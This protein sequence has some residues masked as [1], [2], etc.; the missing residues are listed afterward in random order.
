[1]SPHTLSSASAPR[2]SSGVQI[3][4]QAILVNPVVSQRADP[5]VYRH[6]DGYYY[7]TD[8]VPA[9][10][11]I[12]L[13]RARTLQGLSS[14]T[15]VVVHR[16]AG[17]GPQS[18]WIWAPD[19]RFYD[20]TWYIYYSASPST[21]RFDHRLYSISNTSANPLTG[22]WTQNG[23]LM[24]DWE[25]F[26]IDATSFTSNGRRYLV[27]AQKDP[28]IPG[29]SN[30]YIARLTSPTKITGRQ[31]R[32]SAPTYAWESTGQTVNEAPAVQQRNGKIFLTYSASA[33]DSTYKMGLLSASA[34]ADILN[35]AAWRKSA[36]PVFQ[37]SAQNRVYGPGSN[38]F[39]VSDD[40]KDVVNVYNARSYPDPTPDP[41]RDPNRSIRMQ[42]VNWKPDGTP[43][44][45]VPAATGP[46][47]E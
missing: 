45:G 18:G 34:S 47:L 17:S 10:D 33:T 13:R 43:D 7:L 22:S 38:S 4:N 42:K 25:S 36:Q 35:P 14:A 1:V 15:P 39:T 11:L 2:P 6:T 44:F 23:Q 5:S 32:L 21:N 40:G 8:S 37:T 29:N 41:L 19:I 24:T 28:A 31:V 30:I 3:P 9:Y 16:V 12:E 27:W 26:T 46:T 20:G